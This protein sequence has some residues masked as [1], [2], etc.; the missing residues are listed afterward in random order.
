M[1]FDVACYAV[2]TET[3][4]VFAEG[5]MTLPVTPSGAEVCCLLVDFLMI[6]RAV[7]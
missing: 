3:A 6:G 2:I 5:A 1:V 7:M 4:V